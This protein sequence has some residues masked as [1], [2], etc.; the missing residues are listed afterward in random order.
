MI[1]WILNNY[2]EILSSIFGVF[3]V[4]LSTKQ[5][6]LCWPLGVVSIVLALYVFYDLGLYE[7]VVLQLI[8]FIIT[9]GGWYNWKYG[10][11]N[12]TELKVSNIKKKELLI[13]ISISVI[14]IF[15]FW[16]LFTNYTLAKIP[17]CNAIVSIL[18]VFGMYTQSKKYIECWLILLLNDIICLGIYIYKDLYAFSL[19]YFIF[20][21]LSIIGYIS[22]KKDLKI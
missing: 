12:N 8:V 4:A 15:M 22:W 18:I 9:I 13:L 17:L 5:N 6:I 3:A 16:F 14:L 11:V 2:I 21:I 7:D 19:L 20:G 10:G 1:T